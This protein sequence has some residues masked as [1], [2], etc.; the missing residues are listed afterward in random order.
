MAAG[1]WVGGALLRGASGCVQP[2]L[3][4]ALLVAAAAGSSCCGE[5]A[6][7]GSLG[8]GRH[9][10]VVRPLEHLG[11]VQVDRR[12]QSIGVPGKGSTCM[13]LGKSRLEALP[14]HA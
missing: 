10:V 2:L 11:R 7:A 5:A 9:D 12:E 1:S 4:G 6:M 13:A 3:Q 8:L 14:T